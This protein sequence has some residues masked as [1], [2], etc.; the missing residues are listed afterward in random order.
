[1]ARGL[2]HG[3]WTFEFDGDEGN[4]F[5]LDETLGPRRCCSAGTYEG[6]AARG[7]EDPGLRGQVSMP[8]YVVDAR[9][10]REQLDRARPRVGS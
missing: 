7:P 3:G 9:D 8:K 4:Q 5:K 1:M 6:F 2:K 10:P